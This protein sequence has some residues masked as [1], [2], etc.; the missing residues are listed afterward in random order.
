M[1]TKN[2]GGVLTYFKYDAYNRLVRVDSGGVVKESLAYADTCQSCGGGS[3]KLSGETVDGYGEISYGYSTEGWLESIQYSPHNSASTLIQNEYDN[4]G[5]LKR[6]K[7][8]GVTVTEYGYDSVDFRLDRVYDKTGGQNLEYRLG[9]DSAGNKT[10]ISY[11]NKTKMAYEYGQAYFMSRAD[12]VLVKKDGSEE[13]ITKNR[14]LLRD[15][16]GNIKQKETN[17]GFRTYDYDSLYQLTGYTDQAAPSILYGYDYRGN[18][19]IMTEGTST[20]TYGLGNNN[21]TTSIITSTTASIGYDTRGNMTSR[22]GSSYVWDYKNRLAS[23]NTTSGFI[24]YKYSTAGRMLKREINNKAVYSYFNGDKLL[25]EKDTT[26]KVLKTYTNDNEGVLGM[27]RRV[28]DNNGAFKHV[29]KLYYLFDDL[30]SVTAITN[31]EGIP[32]KHYHYDP[33]GNLTNT[34]NDPL[35]SFTFVGRY[36]GRKDWETGFTQFLHRWYD[37]KTGK[38]ISRDPIGEKGG[39]NLYSYTSNN[40]V[41]LMDIDG[42]CSNSKKS[43]KEGFNSVCSDLSGFFRCMGEIVFSPEDPT[44]VIDK[45]CMFTCGLCVTAPPIPQIKIPACLGCAACFAYL[46]YQI[47]SCYDNHCK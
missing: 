6:V 42:L 24:E 7:L 38:W 35:N 34:D 16:V 17:T 11:P 18:R 2:E 15:G 14:I 1:R 47:Y 9:Y 19:N 39:V 10:S 8:D 20:V 40:P 25:A 28:Y 5:N 3:K 23:A 44:G 13:I 45:V 4:T 31:S 46:G 12:G 32:I 33:Y 27:S 29:Q 26:G 43:F 41:N 21:K 37:A 30:G 36:G 22:M